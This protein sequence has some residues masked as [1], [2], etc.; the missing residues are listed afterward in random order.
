MKRVVTMLCWLGCL[1]MVGRLAAQDQAIG[2][3]LDCQTLHCDFDHFRREITFVNWVRD[4]Q[5]AHVHILGTAQETGGGGR[6]FTF[7]FIGLREFAGRSD[8]LRYVSS[9]TD[10]EAEVRDGLVQTDSSAPTTG[11]R[12]PSGSSTGSA[13]ESPT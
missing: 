3:F 11:T 5:D 12:H 7:A 13:P 1:G 4:R 10:T 2:V 6:E 8:T 9:N